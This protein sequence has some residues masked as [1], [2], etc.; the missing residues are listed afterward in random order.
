M[1]ALLGPIIRRP[2]RWYITRRRVR[3]AVACGAAL[4]VAVAIVRAHQAQYLMAEFGFSEG[5]G[6]KVMDASGNNNGATLLNGATWGA[7]K[8]GT[9]VVLDGTNDFVSIPDAPSL[10]LGRTASLEAWVMLGALNRWNGVLG[11][12]MTDV[13]EAHNYAIEIGPDNKANCVIG[14][15]TTKNVAKAT[16]A[17][18]AQ[19]FYHLTCTWDGSQL[20]LYIDGALNKTVTQTITP[21][22]NNGPL[23]IGQYGGNVDMFRGTIDDVRVYNVAIP[24]TEVITDMNLPVEPTPDLTPPT[25]ALTAP[26]AL[27]T[28][29]GTVALVAS[30]SD[31]RVVVGVRF[32]ID[33]AQLGAEDTVDPY[34]MPWDT[35]TVTN[36]SH[37]VTAV[38][39]D[40]TGNTGSSASTV[41]AANPP[42]LI[43]TTPTLGATISSST[44]DV[45][46]AI[47]GDPAGYPVN[48]VHFQ[49]DGGPEIMDLPPI[50]G[51]FALQDITPGSHILTGF[52]VRPN[53]TKIEG[54]DSIAVSFVRMVADTILPTAVISSPTEGAAVTGTV[55]IVANANDNLGVGGVQF[56]VDGAPVGSEDT[57]APYSVAWPAVGSGGHTLSAVARDLSGNI[58]TS[59]FV[60][61]NV[62]DPND[63]AVRGQWSSVMNWPIVAVHTNLLPTGDILIWDAWE[64]PSSVA[65]LWNPSTGIFTEVAVGAG[66]FCS[67]Q[68]VL[69]DGRVLV[70]GG[71]N[72]TPGGGIPD[73]FTFD[74][75]SRLWTQQPNMRFA[76]WYPG[77]T[78]LGDG[79]VVTL[80]GEITAGVF[81][82]TPEMFDPRTSQW[83]SIA[84]NTSN[85]QETEYPRPFLLPSGRIYAIA[86]TLSQAYTLDVTTPSWTSSG[87][88]PITS[89]AATMFRPGKILMSGGGANGITKPSSTAA[90]VIDMTQASP[91]WRA[92]TPMAYGRYN[93]NLVVLADGQVLAVGGSTTVDNSAT[94]ATLPAELWN[95]STEAWTTMATMHDPR[96]YHSTAMLLPD[97]RVLVAG[98]GRLGSIPSY[99]TAEIY[100]PPY[101]FQ[102]PRPTISNS[103]ASAALGTSF[104]IDSP[105]ASS[106]AKVVLVPLGAVTHTM[107]M[108]QTYVELPFTASATGVIATVPSNVNVTPLNYYMLFLLNGAGVPSTA[109]F[110]RIVAAPDAVFPTVTLTSPL[111]GATVSGLVTLTANASDDKELSDVQFQVDGLNVGAADAA[112]P[113]SATWNTIALADGQHTVRAIARDAANN[114]TASSDVAV[115]VS[116]STGGSRILGYPA[117]G[118]IIDS[119]QTNSINTWRYVTPSAGGVASSLS[120]YISA[121][122]N[123]APNNLFQ[124]A[125]YSDAGGVP[126][127][128]IASTAPAAILAD[129]WNTV[130]LSANLQPNTAYWLAYN[131]NGVGNASN[132][133]RLDPGAPGQMAW[134]TQTFGAWP[135][136]FGA[137]QGSS[138]SQ[139]S[140]FVTYD[141]VV[142]TPLLSFLQPADGASLTGTS[143]NVNYSIT[144]DATGLSVKYQLDGGA[145]GTDPAPLDG[146]FT[147]AGV[148]SGSHTLTGFLI[149]ADQSTVTGSDATAIHF[150]TSTPVPDTTAPAVSLTAPAGG[151]TVSETVT[152]SATA[153]DNVG[154]TSVQFQLDGQNL[155]SPDT[156]NPYSLTWP[157]T[158]VANGTHTLAATASDAAGNVGTSAPM[159]VTVSNVTP[160]P[161]TMLGYTTIGG[162]LDTGARNSMAAWRFVMPNQ[163]GTAS[164][165]SVYIAAPISAA[166]NNQFQ[167]SVYADQGGL[168]G[169]LIVSTASQTIVGN[170]W[171]TVPITATL[172]PNTAY[173]L[174]Y[175][176][177]AT[178]D[179]ANNIRFD[180]G[181]SGQGRWKTRTFGTWPATFGT[182]GGGSASKASIY[183]TYR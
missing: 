53:H 180:P 128:L 139:A 40:A 10:D 125:V 104:T 2:L 50:D 85:M 90:A 36:G 157:T 87:A 44:L 175:N 15:G 31:D 56:W 154:V 95:P 39:R 77:A 169:A 38:A 71:H 62:T 88:A 57:V 93:H 163:T 164:S 108:N 135:T 145:A 13:D 166:P 140:M 121:P 26:S 46:Y 182:A 30:A 47:G 25:V 102:G 92:L 115:T 23:V 96:M 63:P 155:G 49:I 17:M 91:A 42:K 66:V 19:R 100:S 119:G 1:S 48:H 149:R 34:T 179:T 120:A 117:I 84:V 183:I 168:P 97:G 22:A 86:P 3:F 138:G 131:T 143:V 20:K 137:V 162:T 59:A 4:L 74:P 35:T 156:T 58:G 118:G 136:T 75:A 123:A 7:G 159:T 101:L 165:M 64:L 152:I 144:G 109:P 153:S 21:L 45:T 122:V 112:A 9:G 5:T 41:T 65:R 106:I 151:A 176:T 70:I 76:R 129:R 177:N 8:Y 18:A 103:P 181:T 24:Q 28:V 133:V 14:N 173:W 12:S 51:V 69:P 111:D 33:G 161:S 82:N 147:L 142:V 72:G 130:P 89:G 114:V 110:I 11:K 79:R 178:S 29:S 83:T 150:T 37:T 6:T 107:N 32:L 81:A 68:S 73:T 171:N 174:A 27:A 160:P 67:A 99:L 105:D 148:A 167:L 54:T 172:Q 94:G 113:F 170:A 16:V 60:T 134:R 52:L 141:T 55:T 126:G 116:N 78:R 132:T 43:I 127:T 146:A 98:G 80:M 61:V 158:G 124:A